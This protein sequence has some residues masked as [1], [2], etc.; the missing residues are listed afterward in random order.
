MAREPNDPAL[1]D[2]AGY[3][4]EAAKANA[5]AAHWR[6][7]ERVARK[8]RQESRDRNRA[9]EPR[10]RHPGALMRAGAEGEMPVRRAADVEVFRIGELRGIAVRSTNAQRHRRP[11]RKLDAAEFDRLRRHAVAELVRA[12]KT[13][14][15]LDR[16]LGHRGI[17]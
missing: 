3:A 8:P 12:F 2:H 13:Q 1:A 16:R 14:N 6:T 10:Q 4:Q 5:A 15:F 7:A 17:V 11:R 9:F